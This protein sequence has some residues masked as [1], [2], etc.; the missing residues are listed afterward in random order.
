MKPV[1]HTANPRIKLQSTSSHV[2]LTHALIPS[3]SLTVD[4]LEL[5][6]NFL[7]SAATT[8]VTDHCY[9]QST[10]PY[11]SHHSLYVADTLTFL[12]KSLWRLTRRADTL[13]KTYRIRLRTLINKDYTKHRTSNFRMR[14]YKDMALVRIP[15]S[16]V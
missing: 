5:W 15:D 9:E 10:T 7:R 3:C 11:P 16:G 4:S 8:N 14:T 6:L 13:T 12:F 2:F 1:H